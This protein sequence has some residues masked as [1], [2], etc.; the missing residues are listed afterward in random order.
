MCKISHFVLHNLYYEHHYLNY[1]SENNISKIQQKY[2]KNIQNGYIEYIHDIRTITI[3][4]SNNIYKIK[5]IAD[6][7]MSPYIN[8][9]IYL[10]IIKKI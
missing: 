7:N 4:Y 10:E 1:F 3:K 2:N 9:K 6:I 5:K 8:D